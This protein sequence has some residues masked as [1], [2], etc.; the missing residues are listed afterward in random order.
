MKITVFILII[1]IYFSWWEEN[2]QLLI[3]NEGPWPA[4]ISSPM[5][6]SFGT[7]IGTDQKIPLITFFCFSDVR[8]NAWAKLAKGKPRSCHFISAAHVRLSMIKFICS[9]MWSQSLPLWQFDQYQILVES[10]RLYMFKV[11]L[12]L[13][14]LYS[15]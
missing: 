15:C 3:N 8:R 1:L 6:P 9:Y 11:S 7:L 13:L 12:C 10:N 2:S 14:F 4:Y 5:H